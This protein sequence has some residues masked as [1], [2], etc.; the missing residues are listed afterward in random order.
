MATLARTVRGDSAYE[1]LDGLYRRH[2]HATYAVARRYFRSPEDAEDA[3]QETFLNAGLALAGGTAPS[4]P[5]P[6]L[7]AIARNVCLSRLRERGRRPQAVQLQADLPA[8]GAGS[9]GGALARE[10][11]TALRQLPEGQREALVLR[12]LEGRSGTEVARRLGL[13]E[14]ASNALLVRARETLREELEADGSPLECIDVPRLVRLQ[15]AG[16]AP[17]P[18]LRALR[19]HLRRCGPCRRLARGLRAARPLLGFLPDL[20]VR[21]IAWLGRAGAAAKV[22]GATGAAVVGVSVGAGLQAQAPPPDTALVGAGAAALGG[23]SRP[24]VR[25]TRPRAAASSGSL[26]APG[27]AALRATPAPAPAPAGRAAA[28]PGI[29]SPRPAPAP[30]PASAQPAPAPPPEG[31]DEQSPVEPRARAEVTGEPGIAARVDPPLLPPITMTVP[32][33]PASE[34]PV[35]DLPPVELPDVPLVEEPAAATVG[36]DAT[37]LDVT[38]ELPPLPDGLVPGLPG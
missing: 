25:G 33:L 4:E 15:R 36:V 11:A 19:V 23:E 18:D 30:G 13:S 32:D 1:R 28:A 9:D 24:A 22:A 6:W 27:P 21:A 12:E 29:P 31:G 35:P 7:L 17:A 3:V 16:D 5:R 2:R 14:P 37:Q 20:V 26:T 38:V 8:G 10:L 34:L